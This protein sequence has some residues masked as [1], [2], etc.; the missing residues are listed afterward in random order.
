MENFTRSDTFKSTTTKNPYFFFFQRALQL[1]QQGKEVKQN[2][3]G[4]RSTIEISQQ[5]AH[6]NLIGFDKACRNAGIRFVQ[7]LQI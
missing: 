5:S 2:R 1:M 7:D 3:K 4:G 6:T